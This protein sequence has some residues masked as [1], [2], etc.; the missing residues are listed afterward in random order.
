MPR[1][2]L[3]I[4]ILLISAMCLADKPKRDLYEVMG[5][6]KTATQKEIKKAFRKLSRKYHPD[7]NPDKKEWAKEKFVEMANAYEVLK[8]PK[9]R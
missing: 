9:K 5:L 1:S 4:A 7:K 3:I 6:K 2:Q 8:D